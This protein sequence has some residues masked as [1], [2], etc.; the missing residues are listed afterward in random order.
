[1]L[2]L[3]ERLRTSIKESIMSLP[4]NIQSSSPIEKTQEVTEAAAPSKPKRSSMP[5]GSG[6]KFKNLEEL[7]KIS[8]EMY[9]E[10]M[11][12]MA[13]TLCN[14]LRSSLERWKKLMR[15]GRS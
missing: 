13:M 7:K 12:S 8:P 5:A 10:T 6:A 1:V 9:Q 2:K 14:E 11:K 4:E 15:E 3:K